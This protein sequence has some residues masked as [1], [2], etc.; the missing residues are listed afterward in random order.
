MDIQRLTD[1]FMWCTIINGALL[2]LWTMMVALAPDLVYR[3]Q[4]KF[5]PISREAF[6]IIFYSFIGVYKLLFGIFVVI[7]YI[8]LLIIA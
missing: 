4:S 5:F 8:A 1:F 3:T 2:L 7:P 6:H